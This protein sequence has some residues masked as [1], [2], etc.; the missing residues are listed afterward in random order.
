VNFDSNGPYFT[1]YGDELRALRVMPPFNG[2]KKFETEFILPRFKNK[3]YYKEAIN[4][5]TFKKGE[6]FTLNE[7]EVWL[8][9]EIQ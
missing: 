4:P 5:L 9:K 1:D 3:K 6:H 2:K 7:I 8:L